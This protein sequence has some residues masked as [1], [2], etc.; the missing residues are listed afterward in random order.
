[1]IIYCYYK[2][3]SCLNGN[4]LNINKYGNS[5]MKNIKLAMA[6]V[7]TL[8]S[9]AVIADTWEVT[10]TINAGATSA[11]ILKQTVHAQHSVQ[12]TNIIDAG[13]AKVIGRQA[14]TTTRASLTQGAANATQATNLVRTTRSVGT[15]S[16]PFSQ[17]LYTTGVLNMEQ[18]RGAT[19]SLQVANGIVA[20][21]NNYIRQNITSTGIDMDQSGARSIQAANYVGPDAN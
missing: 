13:G 18:N 7:A 4:L 12:G 19:R 11:T 16:T 5:I 21:G 3:Y 2:I 20:T 8:T 17:A 15:S 10:Q 14:L 1:M 6:I 9:G